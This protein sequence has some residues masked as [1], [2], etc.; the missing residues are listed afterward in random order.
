MVMLLMHQSSA[1][2][3]QTESESKSICV[4]MI[5]FMKVYNILGCVQQTAMP[6]NGQLDSLHCCILHCF[7]IIGIFK[8]QGT[9]FSSY[10]R[11]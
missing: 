6:N 3:V 1:W 4:A 11:A 8:S 9:Y 5:D 2:E 7:L 10:S